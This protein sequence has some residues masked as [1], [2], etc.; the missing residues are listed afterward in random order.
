MTLGM[1]NH[2]F[3][4]ASVPGEGGQAMARCPVP[5]FEGA[6]AAPGYQSLP[7]GVKG[8]GQHPMVMT[9]KL[10]QTGSGVHVPQANFAAQV[11]TGQDGG[12]GVN[13]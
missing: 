1:K 4:E 5:E 3:N 8:D 13:V 11:A 10:I 9:P 2:T 7:I 6:I 12:G